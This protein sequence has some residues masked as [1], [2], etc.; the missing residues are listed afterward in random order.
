MK[1]ALLLFAG[2]TTATLLTTSCASLFSE[3]SYPVRINSEPAGADFRVENR[4]GDVVSTGTTP[5][6]VN[7][8][9]SMGYFTREEYKVIVVDSEGM[10]HIQQITFHVDGW[11]YAGNFFIGGPVG[12]LIVDPITGAMYTIDEHAQNIN[13]N[14]GGSASADDAP[15]MNVVDINELTDEQREALVLV[16]E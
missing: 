5:T 9:S 3:S 6:T 8:R 14:L 7:L 16:S 13:F 2:L 4:M 11:Y 15:Q 10:E 1:R 12:W